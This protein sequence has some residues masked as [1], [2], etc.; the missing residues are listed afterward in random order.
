MTTEHRRSP[1]RKVESIERVGG[2]GSVRYIHRLE[3]GHAETRPRAS[4]APKLA[5]V[6]CLRVENLDREMKKFGSGEE[7]T[8]PPID[9][10][11]Q[12]GNND[13]LP[14]RLAATIA[15]RFGIPVEAVGVNTEFVGNRLE[16][17][18]GWVFLSASDVHRLGGK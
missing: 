8:G 9:F 4:S 15:L 18:S 1:R 7:I 10:D 14:D 2:W 13:A 6:T 11:D 16:V 12:P 17:V 5:C 3:C